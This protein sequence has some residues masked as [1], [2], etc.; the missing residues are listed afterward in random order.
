MSE[1]MPPFPCQISQVAHGTPEYE[2]LVALRHEVLRRPLGLA[3]TAEQLAAEHSSYHLGCY[4]EKTLVGCLVLLPLPEKRVQMRQVAVRDDWR[5]RG[6]GRA[7][8]KSAEELARE[9]GFGVI[10]LHA[11]ENAVG[12][13][14]T[15]G[16]QKHGARFWEVGLP[17][18]EMTKMME[19]NNSSDYHVLVC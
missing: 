11:R 19:Q 2:A 17:H 10:V 3:F 14:E 18:W 4:S 5:N 9:T 15:L 7:L 16:Y 8:V 1:S 13:Y 6:V 12:F